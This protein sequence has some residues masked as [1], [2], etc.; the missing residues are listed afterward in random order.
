MEGKYNSGDVVIAVVDLSIARNVLSGDR[1]VI[2]ER[3]I[4]TERI[5]QTTE[6]CYVV[7]KENYNMTILSVRES[8]LKPVDGE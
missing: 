7:R 3:D 8:D 1:C 4:I 6:P 5:A 2:V